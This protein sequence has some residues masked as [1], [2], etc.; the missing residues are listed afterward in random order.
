M[1][2]IYISSQE[3]IFI[4]PV[5]GVACFYYKKWIKN[6]WWALA[7]TA[8]FS[9]TIAGTLKKHLGFDLI[10]LLSQLTQP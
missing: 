3:G 6:M 10:M 8:C 4:A 2:P 5:E 7:S 9:N 1:T